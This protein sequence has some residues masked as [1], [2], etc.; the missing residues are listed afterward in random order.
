MLLKIILFFFYIKLNFQ[1]EILNWH[2]SKK[3]QIQIDFFQNI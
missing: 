2:L 3:I 1:L